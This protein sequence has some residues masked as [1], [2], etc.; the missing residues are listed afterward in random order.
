MT[1]IPYYFGPD[2][3]IITPFTPYESAALLD[4]LDTSI[5]AH[6]HDFIELLLFVSGEGTHIING[7]TYPIKPGHFSLIMPYHVHE[8]R[9]ESE[10]P[11]VFYRCTFDI[12]LLFRQMTVPDYFKQIEYINS[13]LPVIQC[14][15]R[16][17]LLLKKL[18]GVLIQNMENDNFRHSY[19]EYGVFK[20][21]LQFLKLQRSN[22]EEQLQEG[23]VWQAIGYIFQ[24]AC[25][26]DLTLATVAK[27][28]SVDPDDLNFKIINTLGIPFNDLLKEN[29]IRNACSMLIAFPNL[30]I[31]DIS[32]K[33]G[34][35]ANTTF[36]RNFKEIWKMTPNEYRRKYLFRS[37]DG[38]NK[39]IPTALTNE[40]FEYIFINYTKE[41]S[42]E[43]L[44]DKFHVSAQKLNQ[45]FP[46]YLGMTF[47]E[48]V[49]ML[50][51]T[52]AC[53]LLKATN[54]PINIIGKKVGFNSTRSFVRAFQ[55]HI[56]ESPNDY[57]SR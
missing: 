11:L 38:K 35:K 33:V 22:K 45:E 26:A 9:A 46:K 19:L 49:A 13:Y 27:N 17:F 16:E 53:S 39:S 1:V 4:T 48:Y 8:H 54:T 21:F 14:N 40:L 25:D 50:R 36:F 2:N 32:K 57:R 55:K 7:K 51:V 10:T 37:I 52:K 12:G 29:R 56:G 24:N 34:F 42:T 20:L 43:F 30:S 31:T 5:T 18:F 6:R 23:D 47:N 28:V 3:T 41:F 15:E 44:A